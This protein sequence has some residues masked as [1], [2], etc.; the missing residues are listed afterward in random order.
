VTQ[1]SD[2]TVPRSGFVTGLAWTFIALAG[3][4]TLI[5][6]LQNIMLS[7]MLPAEEMREVIRGSE[8]A[9]PMPAFARFMFEHFRLVFASFLVLSA[10]TLISAIGLLKRKNW[11]R[12]IFIGIMG[13]GIVWNLASIAMPFFLFSSFPPIPDHTPA[14]FRDNFD[15]VWK[16]MTAFT[17]AMALGFTVLFGWIIKRLLS[18]EVRQEFLAL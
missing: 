13:L 7:L 17:V 11:A 16:V 9:Q 15:L 4:A 3:F 14:D 18:H 12:L 1:P 6:V 10:V 8:G 2:R 5:T